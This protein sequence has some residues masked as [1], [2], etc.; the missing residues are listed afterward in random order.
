MAGSGPDLVQTSH[1]A[2]ISPAKRDGSTPIKSAAI[3]WL[4]LQLPVSRIVFVGSETRRASG[5][6]VL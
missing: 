1:T 3:L 4:L 5:H 6:P 2:Q